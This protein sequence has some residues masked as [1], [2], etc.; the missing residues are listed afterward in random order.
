MT[1]V[2]RH[3]IAIT[4]PSTIAIE[5][6]EVFSIV[7]E[8]VHGIIYKNSKKEKRV[9]RHSEI[10]KFCDATLM[11]VL[12][13]LKSYNNDVKYGYVQKEL[14]SDEVEYL[15]LFEEEIELSHVSKRCLGNLASVIGLKEIKG[16]DVEYY[17]PQPGDFV[18][19][20]VVSG[21]EYKLDF[22]IGADMLETMLST[23]VLPLYDKKLDYLLC[24]FQENGDEFMMNGKM[25]VVRN[26]EALN[27]SHVAGTSVVDHGTVLFAEVL[28]RTLNGRPLVSTRRLF[29]QPAW[30]QVRHVLFS[31]FCLID[32]LFIMCKT[33]SDY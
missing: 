26:D 18:V 20:V 21:N 4:A 22:N 17:D 19:G 7:Y 30:H 14:T 9:M 12:E 32:R 2:P 3:T 8:P 10:H 16:F 27:G 29:R 11:R 13:G 24:D 31:A 5:E 23:K 15:K 6:Y 25:G 1:I 33:F 28:G